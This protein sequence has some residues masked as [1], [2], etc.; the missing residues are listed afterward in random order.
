MV[1]ALLKLFL[2]KELMIVALTELLLA[3]LD[4]GLLVV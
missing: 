1:I 3:Y 2:A 4:S